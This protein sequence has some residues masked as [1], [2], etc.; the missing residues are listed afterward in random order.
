M[1]SLKVLALGFVMS[2]LASCGGG[3]RDQFVPDND[4]W[5]YDNMNLENA[6]MS[7]DLF[8]RIID[9]GQKAYAPNAKANKE[10]LIISKLWSNPTVN[11]DCC[12]GC[13]PNNVTIRM[14]GG[15]FRRPEITAEGFAL[16]L[17]HEISHAYSGT[18]YYPNT[19]QMSGEGKSD[20][21]STKDAYAKIAALVPEL[22]V[23]INTDS[24]V[25]NTCNK[26]YGRFA[27]ARYS[28]CIHALEGGKS[29]ADLLSTLSG[30]S[31]PN[32]ETPDPLVVT[33]TVT[34]YPDTTQCR[35]DSY[36]AGVLNKSYPKCW[37][38]K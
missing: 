8:N 5:K 38:Y 3:S 4:L 18:P 20:W 14:F 32:Y 30:E 12:R 28:N 11:A 22:R 35:M 23:S 15:L 6:S 24:F 25:K 1:K 13:K 10:T 17:G 31:I 2:T 27:D 7:Q 34:T 19:M 26:A 9:A 29:L 33:K 36:L 16:V 21:A 37:F